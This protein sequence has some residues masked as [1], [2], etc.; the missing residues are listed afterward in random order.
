V[1]EHK[2]SGR[3]KVLKLGKYCTISDEQ[4]QITPCHYFFNK[5]KAITEKAMGD[6]LRRPPHYDGVA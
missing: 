4:Q 1:T 5:N 6:K 2:S 3:Y